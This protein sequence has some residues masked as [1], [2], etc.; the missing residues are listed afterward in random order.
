MTLQIYLP[1]FFTLPLS[2]SSDKASSILLW[3]ARFR[4]LAPYTSSKPASAILLTDFIG[5]SNLDT[6]ILNAFLENSEKSRSDF[7][8]VFLGKALEYYYVVYSVKE[9]GTEGVAKLTHYSVL[10]FLFVLLKLFCACGKAERLLLLRNELSTD[11]RGHYDNAVLKVNAS[12]LAVCQNTVVK[13]LQK[14][15]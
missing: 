3:I 13:Y 4:G 9:F 1:P 7:F 10:D 15:Y 5:E 11:I 12:A 14:A 6:H 2:I 8:D